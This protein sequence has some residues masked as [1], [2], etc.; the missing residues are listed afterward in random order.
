[1]G[2]GER[3][4]HTPVL[5]AKKRF[6][7]LGWLIM[8]CQMFSIIKQ[9]KLDFELVFILHLRV[10]TFAEM[11]S[12][13]FITRNKNRN[14]TLLVASSVDGGTL[15]GIYSLWGQKTGQIHFKKT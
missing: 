15:R 12:T 14:I 3:S 10:W 4:L 2:V 6:F 1:M 5:G 8:Y 7:I 9:K 11:V 13:A